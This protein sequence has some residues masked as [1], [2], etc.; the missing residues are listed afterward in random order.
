MMKLVLAFLLGFLACGLS[1]WLISSFWSFG[2][3]KPAEYAATKPAFDFRQALKGRLLSEG[4]IFDY[5]GRMNIRFVAEMNGTWSEEGGLLTED[6]RYDDG[7]LQA[8]R[9]SVRFGENGAFT[10]T[11][12]DIIGEAQGVLRGGTASLTYKLR[13]PEEAGGHVLDVTDWMYL[14]ENG[15]VMNRSQMRKFGVLAA[16]LIA[17]IRPAESV[18][19]ANVAE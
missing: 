15:V 13:L 7:R 1:G 9:W 17:V 18:E 5:T 10:A 4:V 3:Q 8:R 2:A 11:A 6:F 14:M 19:A 12:P 16:E